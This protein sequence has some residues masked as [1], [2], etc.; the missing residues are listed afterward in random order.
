M[1]IQLIN[2]IISHVYIFIIKLEKN[3]YVLNQQYNI[4]EVI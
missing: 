2:I 4:L 3:K 1:K